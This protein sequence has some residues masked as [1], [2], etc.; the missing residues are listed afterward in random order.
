MTPANEAPVDD[1]AVP[2]EGGPPATR[3]A[4]VATAPLT[5]SLSAA[6]RA[7]LASVAAD[8]GVDLGTLVAELLAEG[9]TLRA[10]EIIERKSAMRGASHPRDPQPRPG[11]GRPPLRGNTP[12]S[13]HDGGNGRS[14]GQGQ[15]GGRA[16]PRGPKP[17]QGHG[18]HQAGYWMEDKAAFL[19]YVRN[20][21]KRGR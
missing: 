16:G 9:V 20:Q 7:K 2:P 18:A 13:G 8:E 4:K 21:E 10:W 19:E 12:Q 17:R 5:V 3:P 15:N 1:V 14:Y 6:L 11:G